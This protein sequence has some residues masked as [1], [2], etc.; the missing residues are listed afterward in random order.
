MI[1]TIDK[2]TRRSLFGRV[3]GLALAI[4]PAALIV[5]GPPPRSL[6][7]YG[8]GAPQAPSRVIIQLAD[9]ASREQLI[10]ESVTLP[11]PLDARHERVIRGLK[12]IHSVSLSEARDVLEEARRAGAL[13]EIDR[14]WSVNAV[15][16]LVD[17]EWIPRLEA[18]PAIARVVPDRRLTLGEAPS[19]APADAILGSS[20][21]GAIAGA[22]A[23]TPELERIGVP[24]VWAEDV[25]GKG[26][27]VANVDSGVNGDDD[28]M[29]DSWRGLFAGSDASWYAPIELTVFP[30]DDL[31]PVG[32]GTPVMGIMAGGFESFG[33]AF[34]ATWIAGDLFVSGAD[35][36]EE[37]H[38]STAIKI[39]EWLVDPDGDPS[40]TTDVPDVVNNSWGIDT[41]RDNQGRLVCDSI[42]DQAIDAMEASGIVVINS[43]GNA[44][45]A[46]ITHRAAGLPRLSVR[47]RSGR[48][49]T[50]TIPRPTPAWDRRRVA[51]SSPPSPRSS[52][53]GY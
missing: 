43:A 51:A 15:V 52:R 11:L 30:V 25:T 6:Q 4:A 17:P 50:R 42:F 47:S 24:A 26:A 34:D 37:G 1:R 9:A 22:V 29:E 27:I 20:A 53:R 14:L 13:T 16:A 21:S 44:G 2:R 46:G 35:R 5:V 19:T 48:S 32:H 49:M 7:P 10:R 28:T 38:V 8:P 12:A 41:N 31:F 36:I 45:D 39:F 23:P 40:T 3:R 18:N 33:V